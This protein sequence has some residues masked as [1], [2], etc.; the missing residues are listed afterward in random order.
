M[1]K[2][3]KHDQPDSLP[4]GLLIPAGG[5]LSL[6]SDHGERLLVI[7]INQK[8]HHLAVAMFSSMVRAWAGR[9]GMA[10]HLQVEGDHDR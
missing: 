4:G 10:S 2:Q 7:S 5:G 6:P 9:L 1:V 3:P 8:H